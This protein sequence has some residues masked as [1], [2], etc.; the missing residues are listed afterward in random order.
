MARCLHRHQWHA[1]PGVARELVQGVAMASVA[2]GWR[3]LCLSR[4]LHRRHCEALPVALLLS[5]H[6][7]SG[8][9]LLTVTRLTR[10]EAL[11]CEL[12]QGAAV[13]SVATGWRCPLRELWPV[14]CTVARLTRCEA[15]P[16][17][18]VQGVAE[19]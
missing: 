2:T 19:V 4:G 15:W 11:P 1:W 7:M 18:L 9:E 14:A 3:C 13:A 5:W 17:E 6:S 16:P 12:V 10:C 8:R